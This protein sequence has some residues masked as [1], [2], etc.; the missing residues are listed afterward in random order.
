MS[1]LGMCHA[2][3][4]SS[5]PNCE[6]LSLAMLGTRI[7]LFGDPPTSV[8]PSSLGKRR[9]GAGRLS[10]EAEASSYRPNASLSPQ[11][12]HEFESVSLPKETEEAGCKIDAELLRI[13]SRTVEELNLNWSF[14]EEPAHSRLDES[15]LQPGCRKQPPHHQRPAPFFPEVH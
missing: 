4:D 7:A 6:K 12:G 1:T 10:S 11:H 5:C 2:L 8:S 15:F 14:P 13:F 3:L 9:S